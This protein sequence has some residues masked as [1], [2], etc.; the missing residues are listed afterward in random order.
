MKKMMMKKMMKEAL[1]ASLAGIGIALAIFT[2]VG[3]IIDCSFGGT[4]VLE[5]YH[6]TRMAVGCILIGIGFGAPSVVYD[7][8][9]V[10]FPLSVILHLGIGVA[11]LMVVSAAVGWIPAGTGI[12]AVI[13]YVA[14]DLA[15]V[16]LIWALFY[17]HCRREARELDRRIQERKRAGSR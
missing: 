6:Y 16:A 17:R 14:A 7:S 9:A 13:G 5:H 1:H 11:I 3:M 8:E 10:S 4:F 2:L 15:A 12:G